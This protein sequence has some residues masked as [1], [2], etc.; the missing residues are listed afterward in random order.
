MQPLIECSEC[1]LYRFFEA[2][3]SSKVAHPL[4]AQWQFRTKWKVATEFHLLIE[5]LMLSGLSVVGSLRQLLFPLMFMLLNGIVEQ[6]HQV[7]PT[8]ASLS[9]LKLC[10]QR[11][12]PINGFQFEIDAS[13]LLFKHDKKAATGVTKWVGRQCL[14]TSGIETLTCVTCGPCGP[15][16]VLQWASIAT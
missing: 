9:R 16:G 15:C 3:V 12:P 11:Q 6:K 5:F 14:Q 1:I 8:A 7:F 10:R 2:C 4:S 13:K